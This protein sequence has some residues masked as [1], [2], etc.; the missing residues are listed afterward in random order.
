M[1]QRKAKTNDVLRIEVKPPSNQHTL[2][3]VSTN[4]QE[5]STPEA[6]PGAHISVPQL[7]PV[8]SH[9]PKIPSGSDDNNEIILKVSVSKFSSPVQMDTTSL[10]MSC[11]V[12]KPNRRCIGNV[13]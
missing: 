10:R 12:S 5:V 2:P 4:L 1:L 3:T 11:R 7:Q 13:S 8:V 6:T 9:K